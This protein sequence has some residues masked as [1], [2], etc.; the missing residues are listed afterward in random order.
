M[1]YMRKETKKLELKKLFKE[2]GFLKIDEEYK[3]ELQA[4]YGPEFSKAVQ[5]L[6]KEDSDLDLLFNN[7][8]SASQS[9][10][11]AEQG[12]FLG[13]EIYDPNNTSANFN[14]ESGV[15][16]YTGQTQNFETPKTESA[17]TDDDVKK[18][19]RKIATKTHPDKVSVKYL[20]DLYMKAQVAYEKNDIF[21]LYL[22]CNDI[23]IDYE[24]A[25]HKLS[26]FKNT[27]KALRGNNS[28][29]EQTYLWAWIHEENEGIKLS[30]IKH[31]IMN[32]RPRI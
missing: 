5:Q 10:V 7:G 25:E 13:I 8:A 26:E 6:F 28:H 31:Y 21:S 15:E 18:L 16:I 20:N 9:N 12:N 3:K 23:D 11:P 29:I 2:F 4:E 24:F 14:P 17:P 32:S 19:Y 30:I 22:I 27:I 1:K